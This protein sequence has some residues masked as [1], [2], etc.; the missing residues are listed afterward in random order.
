MSENL[1]LKEYTE[2]DEEK[3]DSFVLG[4]SYNGT[5]LQSRKFL[6]YHEKGKFQDCSLMVVKGE[7][8]LVAV[9]PA[10]IFLENGT[11]ILYAHPGSTFGGIVFHRDYYSIAYVKE[12]LGLLEQYCKEV[13]IDKVILKQTGEVFSRKKND[14]LFYFYSL[15]GYNSYNELSFCLDYKSLQTDII[16]NLKSKTRNEYRFACKSGL[17]FA[18]LDAD[19]QINDFYKILCESLQKHNAKPVHTYQEILLLR[20]VCLKNHVEFYG[21]FKEKKLIAGSMVF[22]FDNVFHTQYLA[23]NSEYLQY[24]PMN[25]L[26]VELMEE[27]RKL[28][29]GYFS[30]GISTEDHGRVLNESLAKFKEGF[31][32]EC[33]VNK[34]FYKE[35]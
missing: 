7:S 8:T 30:F 25:F 11:K 32:T 16:T 5:I 19:E 18:K 26:N 34:T 21:V 29:F 35:I 31:G 20:D 22:L 9:I 6:N 10:C 12:T 14:L 13:G 23:A 4:C 15:F 28:G 24:K 33:Y 17:T 1:S 27:G 2:N 3:W